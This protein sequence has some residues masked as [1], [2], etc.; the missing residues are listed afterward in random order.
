M[1]AF[2]AC[3]IFFTWMNHTWTTC[4]CLRKYQKATPSP[5]AISHHLIRADNQSRWQ[6]ALDRCTTWPPADPCALICVF[7]HHYTTCRHAFL[8]SYSYES[9]VSN[10]LM[11]QFGSSSQSLEIIVFTIFWTKQKSAH[12]T[13]K[14]PIPSFHFSF[15]QSE[16]GAI[17]VRSCNSFLVHQILVQNHVLNS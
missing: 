13:Q 14:I 17:N 7:P 8:V 1:K 10:F 3:M 6:T 15:P 16:T 4:G 5:T 12:A 9:S 2:A 11:P